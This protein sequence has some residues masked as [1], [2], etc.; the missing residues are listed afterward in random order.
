MDNSGQAQCQKMFI[1]GLLI[2]NRLIYWFAVYNQMNPGSVFDK[3]M[4]VV[5]C[6]IGQCP[7]RL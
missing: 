1:Y 4:S 5:K 6:F 7:G 3:A 2:A